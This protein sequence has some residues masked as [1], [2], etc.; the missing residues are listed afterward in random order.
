MCQTKDSSLSAL[1]YDNSQGQSPNEQ[2]YSHGD[3]TDFSATQVYD[4][5]VPGNLPWVLASLSKLL[6]VDKAL[7]AQQFWQNSSDSLAQSWNY[8]LSNDEL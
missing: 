8:P 3:K 4:Y 7:L 2:R 6:K 5:N 1:D